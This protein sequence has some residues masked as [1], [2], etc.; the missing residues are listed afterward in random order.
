MRL[1]APPVMDETI[2]LDWIGKLALRLR[3]VH[4][5]EV[6]AGTGEPVAG[7]CPA[8]LHVGIYEAA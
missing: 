8:D 4:R 2:W 1:A 3:L 6:R 7:W 5:A